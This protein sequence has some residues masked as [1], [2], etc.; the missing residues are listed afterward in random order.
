MSRDWFQDVLS[1][2]S[3]FEHLISPTPQVPEGNIV[4]LRHKLHREEFNEL[5][6]AM[7]LKRIDLV[8]DAIG[9]L[10]YVLLGTA[11]AYGI[12]MNSVW[13]EIHTANMRKEGGGKRFD[14]KIL[15]PPGWTPP[16]ISKALSSSLLPSFLEAQSR[17][18]TVEDQNPR[19]SLP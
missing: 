3:K 18:K 17:C 5:L 15:K 12:D 9:D 8:A 2:C 19:E 7:S 4:E 1:F 14:G 16:D 13:D 10:I 6:M 11:A